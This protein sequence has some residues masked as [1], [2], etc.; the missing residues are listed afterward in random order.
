IAEGVDEVRLVAYG[1]GRE[2]RVSDCP[3][4]ECLAQNRRA[5]TILLNGRLEQ[6]QGRRAQS[7]GASSVQP[8]Q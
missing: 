3:E 7:G 4:P 5:V 6:M 2:D 8:T 1:R